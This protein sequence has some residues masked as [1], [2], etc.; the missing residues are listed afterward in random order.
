[1]GKTRKSVPTILIFLIIII[2]NCK[3]KNNDILLTIPNT[4]KN[5]IIKPYDVF[6]DSNTFYR[7]NSYYISLNKN[8]SF[9]WKMKNDISNAKLTFTIIW[10]SSKSKTDTIPASHLSLSSLSYSINKISNSKKTI[11]KPK[12]FN[13]ISLKNTKRHFIFKK[14]INTNVTLKKGETLEIDINYVQQNHKKI[15]YGISI[16]KITLDRVEKSLSPPPNVIIIS[17][18]TLRADYINIYKK[19]IGIKSDFNYSPN[20]EEVAKNAAVFF[21][22][23]TTESAT[24]PALASLMLSLYPNEHGC[25]YNGDYLK[26]KYFS[27][28]SF[29]LNKGYQTLALQS[30]AIGFNIVGFE[31]KYGFIDGRNK[32]SIKFKNCDQKLVKFAKKKILQHKNEPFFHWYHFMGTHAGYNP[33]K[34]IMDIIAKDEPYRKYNT[35]KIM[36]NR[37]NVTKSDLE[38]IQKLYAGELFHLDMELKKIF[39][40]LKENGLWDNTLLIITSDHGEDLYQHNQFFYH[41]PSLYNTSLHIPLIIKFP[42]QKKQVLNK[43][44]TSIIDVF[45]TIYDYFNSDDNTNRHKRSFSGISLLDGLKGNSNKLDSRI[46]FAGIKD[47]KIVSALYKNWKIIYNPSNIIVKASH[48]IPYPIKRIELFDFEKDYLERDIQINKQIQTFLIKK[49]NRFW[50]TSKQ[51]KPENIK[52]SGR[53]SKRELKRTLKRLK[54]L[55]YID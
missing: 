1:M 49:I 50:K 28:A 40:A 19:A 18:D 43:D 14:T 47:F 8:N 38:Y 29:L 13:Q 6:Q 17:I 10:S 39:S 20:I 37:E 46:I 25:M 5:N 24:W 12:Q 32:K 41:Y 7:N 48:Q 42:F 9:K 45:P 11:I 55:G 16:P 53:I 34:K 3:Q 36:K 44:L 35:D 27:I 33:P 15:K 54:A 26:Y 23:Y 21:N 2:I 4:V 22:A 51:V 30:N 52:K 31:E